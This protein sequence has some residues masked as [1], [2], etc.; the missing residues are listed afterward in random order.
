MMLYILLLLLLR[1]PY[2]IFMYVYI[3][4]CVCGA[5]GGCVVVIGFSRL[6]DWAAKTIP[7]VKITRRVYTI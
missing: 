6:P 4:M 5:V 2:N 7:N 3:Y 1:V